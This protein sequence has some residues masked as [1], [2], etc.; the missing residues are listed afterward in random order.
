MPGGGD[1][2]AGAPGPD[3]KG[4]PLPPARTGRG[5][6]PTA[7]RATTSLNCDAPF[8]FDRCTRMFVRS[9]VVRFARGRK[10]R[11]NLRAVQHV[12]PFARLDDAVRIVSRSRAGLLPARTR[13]RTMRP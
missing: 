11:P 2:S 8:G 9:V 5:A 12:K 6:G 1:Q 7:L 4:P 3:A 10:T 13:I